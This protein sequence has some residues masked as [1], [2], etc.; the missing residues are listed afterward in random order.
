MIAAQN[1]EFYHLVC[2]DCRASYTVDPDDLREAFGDKRPTPEQVASAVLCT[3]FAHAKR[4]PRTANPGASRGPVHDRW[5]PVDTSGP[6]KERNAGPRV[7]EIT[8]AVRER[9]S[10]ARVPAGA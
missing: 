5:P 2:Q 6:L 10:S 7:P 8:G 9:S 1:G 3:C 4:P